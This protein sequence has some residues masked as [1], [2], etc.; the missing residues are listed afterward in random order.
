MLGLNKP[1]KILVKKDPKSGKPIEPA[2][3]AYVYPAGTT[4]PNGVIH[5][6]N[7]GHGVEEL[8]IKDGRITEAQ[9]KDGAVFLIKHS[10]HLLTFE[11]NG[12]PLAYVEN[13]TAT[14]GWTP[15]D[16][17]KAAA[18]TDILHAGSGKTEEQINT[19]RMRENERVERMRERE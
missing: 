6:A 16:V 8:S 5:T 17:I 14:M 10:D 3:Y 11:G 1:L 7:L 9:K 18:D 13:A 4:L 19:A 2:I 12:H 15:D